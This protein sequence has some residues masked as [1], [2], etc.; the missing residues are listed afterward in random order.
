MKKMISYL[1]IFASTLGGILQASPITD[2]YSKES[3]QS[4]EETVYITRTGKR[5]HREGCFYLKSIIPI[6]RQ[7]ALK[8]GYTP[9]KVCK[10]D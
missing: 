5:Y 8:N 3:I 6:E 4:K 9:C 1:I 2:N 10:P 7:N